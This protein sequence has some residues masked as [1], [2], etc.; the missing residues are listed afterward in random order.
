MN[1]AYETVPVFQDFVSDSWEYSELEPETHKSADTSA[2]VC[3]NCETKTEKILNKSDY[4]EIDVLT[5]MSWR[6]A[7]EI[8]SICGWWRSFK[9]DNYND[10]GTFRTGNT[11]Y[12]SVVKKYDL[13][14]SEVPLSEL[15]QYLSCNPSAIHEVDSYKTE[16]LI[17]D[18]FRDHYDCEVQHTGR[19]GDGGIDLFMI[20]G[21]AN[22]AVQVKNRKYRS[23][24]YNSEPVDALQILHSA[25]RL[26]KSKGAIFVSTA[27]K[28]SKGATLLRRQLVE[29]GELS[30][31]ELFDLSRT[32]EVL[33]LTAE[34]NFER[35]KERV[36][37]PS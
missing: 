33:E 13:Q 10:N 30:A 32:L 12:T 36:M 22:V 19:S 27:R 18:I 29:R 3:P 7:A 2:Q 6:S 4:R 8:C 14:G 28:F 9:V 35:L 34:R 23:H 1:A 16:K 26:S 15:R 20:F 25:A 37:V 5:D 24:R 21:E 17:G 11:A 31:F